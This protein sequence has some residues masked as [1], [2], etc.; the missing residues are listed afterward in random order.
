VNALIQELFARRPVFL[1]GT[2]GTKL[3]ARGLA[4][5]DFP[6]ARNLPHSER[7]ADVTPADVNADTGFIELLKQQHLAN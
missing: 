2:E 3:Q 6:D 5:G 4:N 1:N 7:G